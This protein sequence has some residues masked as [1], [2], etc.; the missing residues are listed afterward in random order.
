[1][2]GGVEVGSEGRNGSAD[3]MQHMRANLDQVVELKQDKFQ[4]RPGGNTDKIWWWTDVEGMK[5]LSG[6]KSSCERFVHSILIWSLHLL[7]T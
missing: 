7:E 2:I 4:G 6:E 3:T 1:M 5:Q